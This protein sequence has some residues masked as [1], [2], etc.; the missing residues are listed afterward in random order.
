[1][2]GTMN[3]DFKQHCFVVMS[4]NPGLRQIYDQGIKRTVESL[5]IICARVDE[6]PFAGNILETILE[7]I[8]NSYFVIADITENRPNC[9]YEIGVAHAIGRPVILTKRQGSRTHFELRG[10]KVVEYSSA[11]ELRDR[12]R[13]SIIGS[14]LTLKPDAPYDDPNRGHFGLK[15]LSNQKLLTASITPTSKNWFKV[16]IA[17]FSVDPSKPLKGKVHFVLHPSYDPSK[18]KVETRSGVASIEVDAFGAYTVGAVVKID[19]TA[20]ELD[21]KTIPGGSRKFYKR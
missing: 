20:L 13:E 15:A 4:F 8:R 6:I 10:F 14:V 21:L 18:R 3:N 7:R 19:G 17:V 2:G 16:R 5:G 1:M 12:L 11:R 9:Y